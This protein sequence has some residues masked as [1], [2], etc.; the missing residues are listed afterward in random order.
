MS[1]SHII[2][3]DQDGLNRLNEIH[4]DDANSAALELGQKILRLCNAF[5][6]ELKPFCIE[7]FT[8]PIESIA[9]GTN[10]IQF[11]TEP[12]GLHCGAIFHAGYPGS[13]KDEVLYFY[14]G[15]LKPVQHLDDSQLAY[16]KRRVDREIGSRST[17]KGSTWQ[18][19]RG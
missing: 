17:E 5:G 1:H 18:H 6:N 12:I 16:V 15:C 7:G 11:T 4:K 8:P 19:K 9:E 14:A 2:V 3:I 13:E 10:R